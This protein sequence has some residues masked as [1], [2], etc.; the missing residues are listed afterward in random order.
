M[1]TYDA[2]L[3]V[4]FGG[5]EGPDDVLP[6][7]ENVTGGRG[8][9]PERLA[10]VGEHYLL[11][12]GVS[13]INGQNRDL[14]AALRTELADRGIDVPV[15]W[16]N[17]NWAP[18]LTDAVTAMTDD[19]VRRALCIV[20]SAYASYSGCRQY[21]EDLAVALAE[22]ARRRPGATPPRLDK[23]RHY[24]NTPGFVAPMVDA[25]VAALAGLPVAD[26]PLA[27]VTHSIP[28]PM[29][30]SA[31][32]H[33]D[34]YEIQHRE[35][36]AL[37]AAGVGERTGAAP[38]WDLVYC[39]RSG[40]PDRPWLEPDVNDH[41]RGLEAGGA[42]GVVVVPIGFISDHMEVRYDLDTEAAETAAG[43]GLPYARAATVGTDPRFVAQ[44][45]DLL[46]ERDAVE[47][48]R[49]VQR[50][51]LGGWGPSHDVCPVGCCPDLRGPRPAACGSD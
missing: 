37:V 1:E 13:P 41:V 28:V 32:P 40:P 38:A 8:I 15:Y 27:F 48:G 44:L 35:V 11:F 16:G 26:V 34:A 5:P 24:F 49:Q 6:F 9:P 43:L 45:V 30:R 31:G 51:A 47:A 25:T 39:S 20:T 12:G 22:T 4:S 10:E 17:R 19:G 14:L 3:L 7:L 36:A 23:A 29:A 21:R 2:V 50:P 46:Q 18:Y 33:G 42:A